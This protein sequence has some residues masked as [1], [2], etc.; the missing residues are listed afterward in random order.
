MTLPIEKNMSYMHAHVNACMTAG[1]WWSVIL[2]LQM[3]THDPLQ[4]WPLTRNSW[5]QWG[6]IGEFLKLSLASWTKN[7]RRE[8]TGG[9]RGSWIS[10]P[11]IIY[12]F[13]LPN[14]SCYYVRRRCVLYMAHS[15]I[16]ST[17]DYIIQEN[18][19]SSSGS[20]SQRMKQLTSKVF[21]GDESK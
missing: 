9:T 1:Y 16:Y 10:E 15:A 13:F 21:L 17:M 11:E 14:Q 8:R 3:F 19:W 12:Y 5:E 6:I 20:T 2:S 7:E 4:C 18:T